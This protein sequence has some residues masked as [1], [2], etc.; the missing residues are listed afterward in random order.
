MKYSQDQV[1]QLMRAT[2]TLLGHNEFKEKA[3]MAELVGVLEFHEYRYYV[4]HEP[5]ISDSEYDKLYHGLR[6]LE[7]AFPGQ[8]LPNSPTQRVAIDL[9][10]SFDTVRHTVP[11]LSLDNSY[12]LGDLKEFD[13]KLRELAQVERVAYA[14]EPKL[15]GSSIALVYENDKLVRAATRGDGEQGEEVT[16]NVM[17]ISS[18]PL[19]AAFSAL[20]IQKVELRG[21]IVI[22]R[23]VFAAINAEREVKGEKSLANPRNASAGGLRVKD[24]REARRRGLDALIYQIGY[25]VDKNG[26]DLLHTLFTQHSNNMLALAKLGF[27][28]PRDQ[29]KVC[30]GIEEVHAFIANWETR[31]EVYEYETDGMVIKA[32][33][34]QVQDQAGFTAHHPRWAIAYK[35]KAKQATTT[36]LEVEFQVGRTGAITPVAKVRPTEL[37]GV[38]IS[39]ISL[40]NED[41]IRQKDLMLGDAVL[42][43]RAGDVIPY[44]VKS[45]AELRDGTQRPIVFPRQCPACGSHT[46]RLE[47][48]AALRCDNPTCPSQMEERII[49]FVSKDG[50]DIEG[51]GRDIVKR[52]YALGLISGLGDIYSLDL[53]SIGQL[54]GWGA[55]SVERLAQGIEESKTRGPER[56][57]YALGIRHVGATTARTLMQAVGHVLDLQ[58]MDMDALTALPDIGPKVAKSIVE[59]FGNKANTEL[60]AYLGSKGVVLEKQAQSGQSNALQGKKFLFTGTLVKMGRTEAERLVEAHGGA[61]LG[62][63]SKNLDYLVAGEKAGSKLDKARGIAS[64]RIITEDEFLQMIAAG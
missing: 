17:T 53:R 44:V 35:F 14:V 21:E 19:V 33:D 26:A 43:E 29:S 50:M 1:H 37:A 20:G 62:G 48:E 12:D 31:R 61:V 58:N 24:P 18:V 25:A 8:A 2:H 11:M 63:V 3:W 30:M 40:H 39:S 27:K 60:I 56:L 36:L 7:L 28:V 15:D 52:F 22:A 42:I 6:K 34:R 45:M 57:L 16:A 49:H 54:E 47:G 59:F 64:I 23:K 13:R 46:K 5:L 51:L 38:T 10:E 32:N 41:I 4:L 55:R 9:T